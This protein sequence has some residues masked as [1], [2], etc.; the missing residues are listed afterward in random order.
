MSSLPPPKTIDDVIARM[1][2]ID[3]ELATKD[4]VAW[5]NKLY[6]RVTERVKEWHEKGAFQSPGFLERLDVVFAGL[7]FQAYEAAEAG[8]AE[9]APKAWVP[10]FARREESAIAPIQF[11]LAG[12]NAHINYDLP[13]GLVDVC[14][15]LGLEVESG[16]PHHADFEQVNQLLE[17]VEEEVKQWFA[18]GFV[19]KLDHTFGRV[20]DVIA[21]WSVARARDQ[22]WTNAEILSALGDGFLRDQFLLAHGRLVGAYGRGLLLPIGELLE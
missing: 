21:M 3:A 8:G 11:A 12:M 15:E 17:E 2:A 18:T 16:T 14:A 7:Y 20:D 19:G 1:R 4:G 6:L 22:S 10:L 13:V 5:F 9:A